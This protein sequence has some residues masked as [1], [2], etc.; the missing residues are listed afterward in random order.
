MTLQL[1]PPRSLTTDPADRHL[2]GGECSG[3]VRADDRGAS[4]GLDGGQGAH[5]GVLLG[6]TTCSQSK[7]GGDDS[8]ETLR[9]GSH[10]ESDGNLEVVDG[11][12]GKKAGEIHE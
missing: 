3:L 6:H 5:D 8:G 9:N 7:A 12:L 1:L 10:S 11:T 2:V 4:E